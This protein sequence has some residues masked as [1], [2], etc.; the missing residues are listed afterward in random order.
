[1][2]AVTKKTT[3]TTAK[4]VTKKTAA[5]QVLPPAP[6]A[7]VATSAEIRFRNNNLLISPRKLRLLANVVKTLVPAEALLRLKF[8]N[9]KSARI[10][11]KSIQSAV[12]DATRNHGLLESS[13]RFR[14]IRVDEGQKI[15][16]MDKSHGSRFNRGVIIKRHSRLEIMLTG[17]KQ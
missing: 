1:M 10:L 13:L 14:S 3:K 7:P 8:T 2:P 5:P 17:Q 15:K 6:V 11:V 12:N 4:P 16:R 9:S